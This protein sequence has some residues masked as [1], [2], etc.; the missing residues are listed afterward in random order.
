[1]SRET[2]PFILLLWHQLWRNTVNK[3][4]PPQ[5]HLKSL[6]QIIWELL[7]LRWVF[8]F[9]GFYVFAS[10]SGMLVCG[11]GCQKRMKVNKEKN[12]TIH[13]SPSVKDI[14]VQMAFILLKRYSVKS[15]VY[16]SKHIW[17]TVCILVT[18]YICPQ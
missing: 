9:C 1:M 6:F 7:K 17:Y 16:I 2:L 12:V 10:Y 14:K 15:Y 11:H 8:C 4:F 18:I 13:V 3:C 5:I